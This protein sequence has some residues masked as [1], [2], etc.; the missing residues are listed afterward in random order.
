MKSE[1]LQAAAAKLW[2][3][4]IYEKEWLAAKSKKFP[5]GPKPTMDWIAAM[6]NDKEPVDVDLTLRP[7]NMHATNNTVVLWNQFVPAKSGAGLITLS[8]LWT[9]NIRILTQ[10]AVAN[11]PH[12]CVLVCPVEIAPL[13]WIFASMTASFCD[14]TLSNVRIS[15]IDPSAVLNIA[16]HEIENMF[17]SNLSHSY[18]VLLEVATGVPSTIEDAKTVKD[19][20]AMLVL[21][22]L[23]Q[24]F[25][26][27]KQSLSYKNK[28]DAF[29]VSILQKHFNFVQVPH[30]P[31]YQWGGI[32]GGTTSVERSS[33]QKAGPLATCIAPMVTAE[34]MKKYVHSMSHSVFDKFSSIA[35][36]FIA[37]DG[38][39]GVNK[40]CTR[41]REWFTER[42]DLSY[43]GEVFEALFSLA[44]G[45][46][47]QWRNE[48]GYDARLVL[49]KIFQTTSTEHAAKDNAVAEAPQNTAMYSDITIKAKDYLF[50]GEGRK[51]TTVHELKSGKEAIYFP[52]NYEY[53]NYRGKARSTY[54]GEFKRGRRT[55]TGDESNLVPEIGMTTYF[56][57]VRHEGHADTGIIQCFIGERIKGLPDNARLLYSGPIKN[58]LPHGSGNLIFCSQDSATEALKLSQFIDGYFKEGSLP[59][60]PPTTPILGEESANETAKDLI[61][62]HYNKY[63]SN[64]IMHYT[65]QIAR[66]IDVKRD[67]AL[68]DIQHMS[69]ESDEMMAFSPPKLMTHVKRP[70]PITTVQKEESTPTRPKTP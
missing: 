1:E 27:G 2:Q 14:N 68:C 54:V 39:N 3:N 32:F 55:G 4:T 56:K 23:E 6:V 17:K 21:G 30:I 70:T 20:S 19:N 47:V 35:R 12:T 15:L 52:E 8:E 64:F 62:A 57:G 38:G 53:E 67:I 16:T 5:P 10:Y 25:R 22:L 18:N 41:M 36:D 11:Q 58:K 49:L 60:T 63:N 46:D 9:H 42:L 28:Y 34:L 48:S 31:Q 7:V 44:T 69:L 45:D 66:S 37:S 40:G 61:V 43:G 29:D 51:F 26:N 65:Q 13:Q 59:L 24:H 50:K 33:S